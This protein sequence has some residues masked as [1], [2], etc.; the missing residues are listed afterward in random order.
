MEYQKIA[1]LIHGASNQNSKFRTL[2]MPLINCEVDFILEWSLTCV[3]T[4][5]TGTGT[6]KITDTKL[7]VLEVTLSSPDNYK[8]LQ[9]LNSG[10]KL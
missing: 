2:V 10:F 8:L 3:I 7:F 4:N 9:Q 5:S 1:N 6:L